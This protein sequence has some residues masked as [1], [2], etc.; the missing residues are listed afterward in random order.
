MGENR[1]IGRQNT[2]PWHLPADLRRFRTMTM[3]HPLI[4]GRKTFESIG[5]PLPGRRMIVLTR[6]P[7]LSIPNVEIV[8]SLDRALRL[9]VDHDRTFVG[10]GADVYAHAL[11]HADELFLTVVHEVIQGDARFPHVPMHGW[12][13]VESEYV[14]PDARNRYPHSVRVY[15]RRSSI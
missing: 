8:S 2:I 4:V 15:H 14:R 9:V 6:N 10:G 12:E 11:P 5:K 13:L 3:G 7:S 1:V